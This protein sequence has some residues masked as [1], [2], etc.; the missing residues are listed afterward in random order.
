MYSYSMRIIFIALFHRQK[1]FVVF[2]KI[3]LKFI[4][5]KFPLLN[6]QKTSSVSEKFFI[7]PI[8]IFNS[9]TICW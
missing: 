1:H 5:D 4:I 2:A 6:K 9:T 7:Y 8:A 3:K